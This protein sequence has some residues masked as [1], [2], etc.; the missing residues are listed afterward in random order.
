M[1]NN[2]KVKLRNFLFFRKK[3]RKILLFSFIFIFLLVLCYFLQYFKLYDFNISIS[4]S[5]NFVHQCPLCDFVPLENATSTKRDVVLASALTE[6]KRVEYFLRTLRT[7]KTNARIILFLD[8]REIVTNKWQSLFAHCDI[9]PVFVTHTSDVVKSAPKLSRYYF[10]LEWLKGH[11][12]E[13]DRVLHTDTFDVIF[14]SDPFIPTID[15]DKLY[16]TYEPVNLKG[17]MWTE[18]WIKQCYGHQFAN[19]HRKEPV[20]CSGVTIGGAKPFLTYLETLITTPKWR[21]CFGHSLDQAHHNAL[22]YDG[23]FA[24][25]GLNIVGFGCDSPFLTMHFCCK[26]Y[27]C[28]IDEDGY[29]HGNHSFTIPVLVHQYNRWKNLTKRNSV[30]CPNFNIPSTGSKKA[31]YL[32]P[33]ITKFPK[34][35]LQPP[36]I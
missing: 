24:K 23:E 21:T 8:N 28:R 34:I 16:F 31:T 29:V 26:K 12:D 27:K 10:E 22:L 6:L 36:N 25:K 7:T 20:S 11:I 9:E 14:Q 2:M 18:A 4:K 17:S 33:I 30:M 19:E 35:T 13:I 15:K 1:F 3:S 32:P 5:E